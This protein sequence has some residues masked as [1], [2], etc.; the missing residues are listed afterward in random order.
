VAEQED[1]IVVTKSGRLAGCR[2]RVLIALIVLAILLLAL[3][4][5]L[6]RGMLSG[7]APQPARRAAVDAPAVV[8]AGD[9]LDAALPARGHG[10]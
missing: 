7:T 9:E 8:E 10:A 1:E 3:A 6:V 5:M 4:A 2:G